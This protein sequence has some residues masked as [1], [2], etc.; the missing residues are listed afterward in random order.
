M[1]KDRIPLA[2]TA[3]APYSSLGDTAQGADPSRDALSTVELVKLLR[4]TLRLGCL[5]ATAG[6]VAFRVREAMHRTALGFGASR[7]QVIYDVDS[8]HASIFSGNLVETQV[9]RVPSL[10]VDMNRISKVEAL[11]RELVER[12]QSRDIDEVERALDQIERAPSP[13][14][15][16][17]TPPLLGASCGAF[18]GV[19]GGSTWQ[20]GA[21]FA[22]ALLGHLLRLM[23]IKI[24][25]PIATT[26]ASCAFL[27][28]LG[29]WGTAHALGWVA[30]IFSLAIPAG[31]LAPGKA[32]LASVLYLIPGVPLVSSLLDILNLD[33]QAG[34]ARTALATL[35]LI[36]IA[37]GVLTFLSLTG[38]ALT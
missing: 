7:I 26:V 2:P 20:M 31:A 36:C 8:I 23:H 11:S 5:M 34:I 22:G 38:F 18:C 32:I 12:P 10:A 27:S 6:G 4:L 24:R 28:A 21:A 3:S 13:Y 37:V 19:I 17:I 29:S 15:T 14:P 1:T 16:W 9:A 35:T 33:I 25:S 30:R